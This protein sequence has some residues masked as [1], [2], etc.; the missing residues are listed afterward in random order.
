MKLGVFNPLFQNME[1][2]EMLDYVKASGL[3]AVEVGTGGYPGNAHCDVDKLLGSEG[4]RSENLSEFEKRG[5]SIS[6]YSCHGNPIAPEDALRK[7]YDEALRKKIEQA[8]S[9]GETGIKSV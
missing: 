5:L 4:A 1:L 9:E 7:E 8:D 3:D 2:L 6:G